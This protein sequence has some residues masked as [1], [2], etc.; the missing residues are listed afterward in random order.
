[1]RVSSKPLKPL[2]AGL[3]MLLVFA[4]LAAPVALALFAPDLLVG[5]AALTPLL[6]LVPV[7]AINRGAGLWND[8]NREGCA[9]VYE[10]AIS[11]MIALGRDRLPQEIVDVLAESLESAE[12]QEAVEAAW[13]YR[14]ALDRIYRQLR[15]SA[16]ARR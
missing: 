5:P 15:M 12:P 13:T 3:G 1:M 10:V 11:A 14:N 8:G 9:A 6:L 4:A 7:V 16:P 2:R